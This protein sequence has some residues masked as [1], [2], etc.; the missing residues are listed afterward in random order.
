MYNLCYVRIFIKNKNR[1]KSS[2]YTHLKFSK[3]GS[4]PKKFNTKHTT[5]EWITSNTFL[6]LQEMDSL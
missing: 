1:Q 2:I 4:N 6:L 5:R 3:F